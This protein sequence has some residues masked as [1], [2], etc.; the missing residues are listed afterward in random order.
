[1][2]MNVTSKR[3]TRSF[4]KILN[5]YII[6]LSTHFYFDRKRCYIAEKYD[7][8]QQMASEAPV[9]WLKYKLL[10]QPLGSKHSGRLRFPWPILLFT[11]FLKSWLNLSFDRCDTRGWKEL[12]KVSDIISKVF[13]LLLNFS[14]H[15]RLYR[16]KKKVNAQ[17]LRTVPNVSDKWCQILKKISHFWGL[18][19]RAWL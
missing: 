7:L 19:Q 12:S 17:M 16:S 1:M 10:K 11:M 2:N 9:H 3:W 13:S 5:L 14:F 4:V 15:I 18:F 8:N 6:L